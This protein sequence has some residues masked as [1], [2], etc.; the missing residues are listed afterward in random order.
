M[1]KLLLT[2]FFVVTASA[3]L[4]SQALAEWTVAKLTSTAHFTVDGKN[5]QAVR[6][7]MLLQDRSWVATSKRGRV[8]LVNG[9]DSILVQPDTIVAISNVNRKKHE[10]RVYQNKGDID[11]AIKKGLSDRVQVNTP[12]VI[13]IV[14]G[15]KFSVSTDQTES[16]VSVTSG[17]VAVST[18]SGVGL[19]TVGPGS[20]FSSATGLASSSASTGSFSS[21]GATGPSGDEGSESGHGH[22]GGNGN[23]YGW[24]NGNNGNRGGNGNQYG[25]GNGIRGGN[26]NQYGWGKG[27]DGNDDS[28][29]DG[30]GY[31]NGNGDD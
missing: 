14:K 23:H 30:H 11:L 21:L 15:T 5:W 12:H 24:E 10:Y 3:A 19:G 2:L 7:G 31:G 26:G 28:N 17:R 29:D 9:I 8:L 18:P 6:K 25:W 16:T 20:S 22:A 27:N 1:S 13:A 4:P